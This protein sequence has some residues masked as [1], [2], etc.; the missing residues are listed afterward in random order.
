MAVPPVRF[1]RSDRVRLGRIRSFLLDR[2]ILLSWNPYNVGWI[3]RLFGGDEKRLLR[4]EVPMGSS[5]SRRVSDG[6]RHCVP[7]RQTT[8]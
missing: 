7:F 5:A 4:R 1:V 3:W 8:W 6:S 2:R